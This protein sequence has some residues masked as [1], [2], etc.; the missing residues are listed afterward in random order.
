[1]YGPKR[2]YF[3]RYSTPMFF[4]SHDLPQP[5]FKRVVYL[6][7]DGRDVMVSYF[8]HF[9]AMEG[10]E[11]DLMQVVKGKVGVPA[12]YKWHQ[13]VETW[14]ANPFAAQMLAIKYEDLKNNPVNELRRFCA[15]AGVEREGAWLQRI[16]DKASFE[17]MRQKEATNG[18][19]L[20]A[21][22][23]DKAFVR[24][25]Q[26]GSHKDEMPPEVLEVFLREA[27]DTLRKLG[28]LE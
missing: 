23:K 19:G 14:L 24:R 28:Y 22:P 21:W 5:Y 8:H 6:I 13:H 17:N 4:K 15:F 3:K 26:V 9:K 27:G 10:K 16:A 20:L 25:G 2:P 7:R 18:M 11:V 1:N 12:V